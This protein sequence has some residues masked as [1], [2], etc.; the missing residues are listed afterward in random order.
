MA[1]AVWVIQILCGVSERE[2]LEIRTFGTTTR[3]RVGLREWLLF[4]I[5]ILLL[6]DV[7]RRRKEFRQFDQPRYSLE[8]PSSLKRRPPWRSAK[9][10][11]P[12][13]RFIVH[14]QRIVDFLERPR[15]P[16]LPFRAPAVHAAHQRPSP[17]VRRRVA[18]SA[19]HRNIGRRVKRAETKAGGP[20]PERTALDVAARLGRIRRWRFPSA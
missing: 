16:A 12:L 8:T 19:E 4:S 15:S 10:S 9:R 14:K 1:D 5:G 6:H 7:F 18:D 20:V 3:A 17:A 13:A 2:S 11:A